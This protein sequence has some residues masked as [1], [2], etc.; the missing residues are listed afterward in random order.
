MTTE[1]QQHP[2]IRKL[3]QL[4]ISKGYLLSDEIFAILPEEMLDTVTELDN[5]YRQLRE[6]DIPLVDRP[7]KH[8][9][10]GLQEATGEDF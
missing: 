10:R 4:G 9:S 1:T 6:L 7:E 2:A 3:L 5:V 8:Q